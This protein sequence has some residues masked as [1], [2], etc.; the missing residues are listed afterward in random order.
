MLAFIVAI[1]GIAI[2]LLVVAATIRG[3]WRIGRGNEEMI[4]GGSDGRQMHPTK[5]ERPE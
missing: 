4:P 3:V 1:V 2:V 5:E